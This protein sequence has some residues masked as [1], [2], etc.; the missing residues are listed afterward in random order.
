MTGDDR[1][2][3]APA[4]ENV[5]VGDFGRPREP[6]MSIAFLP[7]KERY[8]R[9]RCR[10]L[11]VWLDLDN[12]VL[13][14]KDC[15]TPVEAFDFLVRHARRERELDYR[16][17]LIKEFEEKERRKKEAKERKRRPVTDWEKPLGQI[18]EEH[19]RLGCPRAWMWLTCKYI[20][21][22]CGTR[23]NRKGYARIEQEVLAARAEREARGEHRRR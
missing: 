14:C 20:C 18:Q 23:L 15:G 2:P 17:G 11:H 1:Q 21:C 13:E 10:H 3:A 19:H 6:G 5:I 16:V 9:P 22:Y 12:R 4:D 7:P 8:K